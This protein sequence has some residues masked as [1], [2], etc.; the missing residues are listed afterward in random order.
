MFGYEKL[1]IT[2]KAYAHCWSKQFETS[3]AEGRS[4][5]AVAATNLFQVVAARKSSERWKQNL[6]GR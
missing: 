6:F 4:L 5:L 2:I 3:R 1:I